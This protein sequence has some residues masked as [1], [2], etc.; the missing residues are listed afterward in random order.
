MSK[1]IIFSMGAR[2]GVGKTTIIS[3]L[4]DWYAEN[5]VPVELFDFDDE[6]KANSGLSHFQKSARKIHVDKRDGL[7]FFF[8]VADTTTKPIILADFGAR[9]G[10]MTFGWFDNT[11]EYLKGLDIAFTAVGVV[12]TDPGSV[13]SVLEWADHLK[14]RVDYLIVLNEH[15]T[16]QAVFDVWDNSEQAER[17]RKELKPKVIRFSSINPDLQ[18]GISNHGASLLEVAQ[19]KVQ[20]PELVGSRWTIRAQQIYQ[21]A[22]KEFARAKDVLL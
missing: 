17:L 18:K 16:E 6:N 7:D 15:Q 1:R 19:K 13:T 12:T 2:G 11:F 9:S 8:D 22:S 4:A 5:N 14:K 3:T 10:R 20:I 21:S